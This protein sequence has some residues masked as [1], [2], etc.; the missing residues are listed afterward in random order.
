MNKLAAELMK[1]IDDQKAECV[2]KTMN[3]I[4]DDAPKNKFS[5]VTGKITAFDD[6]QTKIEQLEKEQGPA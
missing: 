5:I 4:R 6:I 3:L 1:W 2:T